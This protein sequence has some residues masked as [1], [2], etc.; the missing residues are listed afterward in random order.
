MFHP[1]FRVWFSG[2]ALDMHDLII[3]VIVADNLLLLLCILCDVYLVYVSVL[4]SLSFISYF[5]LFECS[6]CLW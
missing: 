4:G 5:T 1:K 3:S 2:V 6:V